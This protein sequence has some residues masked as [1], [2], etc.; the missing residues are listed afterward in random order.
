M[1]VL[2][3]YG[4]E[5]E[6]VHVTGP[7]KAYIRKD[8]GDLEFHHCPTC[9]TSISWRVVGQETGKPIAVN[10]RLADDPSGVSDIPIRHFDGLN[11][12]APLPDDGTTVK[13]L[14][15]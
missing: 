1:G 11:T 4:T 8:G 6:D 5:G 7:T 3:I 9:G 15:S 13:D 14:W 10:L 2:W 12:F